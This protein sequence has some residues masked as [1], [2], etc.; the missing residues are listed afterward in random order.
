[1]NDIERT[2]YWWK[3]AQ[4]S[5]EKLDRIRKLYKERC[6]QTVWQFTEGEEMFLADIREVLDRET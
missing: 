6:K 3:R 1:M 5:E 2:T 4:S